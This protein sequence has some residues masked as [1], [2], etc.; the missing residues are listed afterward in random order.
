[1]SDDDDAKHIVLPLLRRRI[2]ANCAASFKLAVAALLAVQER[3][4]LGLR[5]TAHQETPGIADFVDRPTDP[6][7]INLRGRSATQLAGLDGVVGATITS[8]ALLRLANRALAHAP[9]EGCSR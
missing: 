7:R 5:V 9:P 2:G 8:R 3:K 1:M 4:L 6:W